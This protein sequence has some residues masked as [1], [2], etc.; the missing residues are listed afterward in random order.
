MTFD[1]GT[2][3]TNA[4]SHVASMT[5]LWLKS[6][7]AC[8]SY[9]QML[10]QIHNRQQQQGTKLSLY[11]TCVFPAKAGDTK[12]HVENIF[13]LFPSQIIR[14]FGDFSRLNLVQEET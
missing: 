8:G 7:K 2:M 11:N 4:G 6:I 14:F 1:L 10:T 13:P 9:S 5:Q 12:I 3:S